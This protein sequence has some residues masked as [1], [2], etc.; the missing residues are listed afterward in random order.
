MPASF[1]IHPLQPKAPP[2]ADASLTLTAS[3]EPEPCR[4][5]AS[6][7]VQ[8]RLSIAKLV[9]QAIPSAALSISMLLLA[10][11]SLKPLGPDYHPP[12]AGLVQQAGNASLVTADNDRA[13]VATVTEPLPDHWWQLY[14]NPLLD[15]LVQQALSHNT[16][17]RVA[18]ATLERQQA[19]RQEAD[20]GRQPS[21]TANAKPYYGHPSGLSVLQPGNVPD[22]A[23][24]Y[25]SGISLSYQVD[26]FGQI[27]RAIE[28]A[29]ANSQA[30][31]AALDLVKI[32]VAANTARAY[33]DVCATGL[34]LHTA[35]RSIDLQQQS[36]DLTGRLLQAGRTGELDHLRA[37]AQLQQLNA[38]LPPLQA[39]RQNALYRLA[40]LSGELPQ[41]FPRQVSACETPPQLTHPIPLGDGRALLQRRPDIRQNERLLA[42]A[43]AR[44]GVAMADLYPKISLGLTGSAAGLMGGIGQADTLGW[45]LG[46]LIS[47]TLPNTGAAQARI[48]QAEAGSREQLAR[49]DGSVLKALEEV[50]MA[51]NNY[52][53]ELDRWQSLQAAVKQTKEVAD[54]TRLLYSSGKIG[55]LEVLDAERSLA[56]SEAALAQS[57]GQ[58]ADHQVMLFLALGGGWQ[59]QSAVN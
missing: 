55:Y 39:R 12:A 17:L 8:H 7:P 13:T 31:E 5:A 57:S 58:L 37:R 34:Q 11:C 4:L 35:R 41:N 16:D 6:R 25:D 28:V 46:P 15:R 18:M 33:A 26:L 56:S 44:V 3:E 23:W 49:F 43:T 51:L 21:L 47:W 32:T 53:R 52:A 36:V 59:S 50:E 19:L 1:S 20:S 2:L 38:S 48:A 27:R 42:G 29:D 14:Q 22:N 9:R 54:K 40:T 45:S 24:R 10:A 30:A